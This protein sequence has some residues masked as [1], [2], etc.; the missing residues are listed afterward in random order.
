M[1]A[2]ARSALPNMPEEVFSLWFDDVVN[3]LGWPPQGQKWE[4]TLRGYPLLEWQRRR[5]EKRPVDLQMDSFAPSAQEMIRQLMI[6]HLTGIDNELSA[7][8]TNWRER[9]AS[10]GEYVE[11]H[12]R[13]PAALILLECGSRWQ[14]ADGCHRLAY[15]FAS[16][17]LPAR[18]R[19]LGGQQEAWVAVRAR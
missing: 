11:E 18:R 13:L 5:W 8:V 3:S 6:A 1:N 19:L 9:F 17:I 12:H 15:Y 14:I 10:I 16:R 2:E 4:M 7:D